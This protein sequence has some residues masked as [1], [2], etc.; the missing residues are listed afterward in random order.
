MNVIIQFL[1]SGHSYLTEYTL[2]PS[3]YSDLIYFIQLPVT[4]S[5]KRIKKS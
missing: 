4:H 2:V 1:V 5:D 3:L